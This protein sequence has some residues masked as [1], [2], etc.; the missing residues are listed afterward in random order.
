MCEE[1]FNI[2][3]RLDDVEQCL[4]GPQSVNVLDDFAAGD[5][6]D[7]YRGDA[8]KPN[9]AKI[10]NICQ[11]FGIRCLSLEEFMDEQQLKR[12]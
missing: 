2:P 9:A 7:R 8:A 11:H 5:L 3:R 6:R 12:F 1:P 4:A 10:L